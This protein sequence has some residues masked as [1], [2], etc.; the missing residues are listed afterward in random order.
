MRRR[1]RG[2]SLTEQ[3]ETIQDV[4][5]GVALADR[6]DCRPMEVSQSDIVEEC[7]NRSNASAI[8]FV[9]PR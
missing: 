3:L 8:S 2:C 6:R 7:A 1:I 4:K 9:N 5:E